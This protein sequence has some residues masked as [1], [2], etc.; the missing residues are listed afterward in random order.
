MSIFEGIYAG[1]IAPA[2]YQFGAESMIAHGGWPYR[3]PFHYVG[4]WCLWGSGF[5]GIALLC[6]RLAGRLKSNNPLQDDRV[7]SA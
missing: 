4:F 6:F 5:L 3:S 1:F 2:R 7:G